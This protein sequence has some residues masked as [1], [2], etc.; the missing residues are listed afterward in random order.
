LATGKKVRI[1]SPAKLRGA[2]GGD[3]AATGVKKAKGGKKAKV[4]AEAAQAQT[5]TPT[6][7]DV[8]AIPSA[9]TGEPEAK[10]EEDY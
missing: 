3:G 9:P 4:P 6:G 2:V 5:S 10:A 1:K 7:E 8:A